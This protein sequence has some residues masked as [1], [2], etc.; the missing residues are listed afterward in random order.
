MDVKKELKIQLLFLSNYIL[1]RTECEGHFTV[2]NLEIAVLGK[3]YTVYVDG[4]FTR[5]KREYDCCLGILGH[6]YSVNKLTVLVAPR[7]FDKSVN[8]FKLGFY[9]CYALLSFGN[10]RSCIGG[11]GVL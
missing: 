5:Q 9:A 10:N 4:V 1:T 3:V 11:G 6:G 8:T 2:L 7:G